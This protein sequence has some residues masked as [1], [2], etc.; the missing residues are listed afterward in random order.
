[1]QRIGSESTSWRTSS[2][3]ADVMY[4]CIKSSRERLMGKDT[5]VPIFL[6]QTHHFNTKSTPLAESLE[7]C[8]RVCRAHLG[9]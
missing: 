7:V 6:W 1:M 5:K 8:V 3:S 4:A 9:F 2:C